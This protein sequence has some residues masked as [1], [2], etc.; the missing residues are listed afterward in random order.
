MRFFAN[1]PTGRQALRMTKKIQISN[2]KSQNDG[3][4]ENS[5]LKAQNS[6]LQLKTL[7]LIVILR[8]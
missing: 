5:K 2:L 8:A 6:K 3:D 7:K 1:L 4:E